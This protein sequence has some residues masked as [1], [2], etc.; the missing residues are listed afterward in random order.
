MACFGGCIGGGGQPVPTDSKI[1]RKRAQSLYKIDAAKG[2]RKEKRRSAIMERPEKP[3][4]PRITVPAPS[5]VRLFKRPSIFPRCRG[6]EGLV[7]G[8]PGPDYVTWPYGDEMP[9]VADRLES[10]SV[11]MQ[12]T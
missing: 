10:D 3:Y 1:R 4:C 5:W 9:K 7:T 11:A 6:V 12:H 8:P 2:G